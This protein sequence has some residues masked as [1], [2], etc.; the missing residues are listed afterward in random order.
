MQRR[1]VILLS[2]ILGSWNLLGCGAECSSI[3]CAEAVDFEV[4][5]PPADWS[6]IRGLRVRVCRNTTC[7]SGTCASLPATPEDG[8][9]YGVRL[10]GW[11]KNEVIDTF[12]YPPGTL[13]IRLQ[14]GPVKNGDRYTVTVTDATGATVT[15]FDKT[16]TYTLYEVGADSC[17]L[18]CTRAVFE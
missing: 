9:G 18:V 2:L 11:P 13:A 4:P 17:G 14:E 12:V 15:A 10:T 5:L 6:T 3:G 7:A 16:A 8:V 1:L